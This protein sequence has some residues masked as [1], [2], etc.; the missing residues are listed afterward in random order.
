MMECA[1][2]GTTPT[3][4]VTVVDEHGTARTRCL[5]NA[6]AA[7]A[8]YPVPSAAQLLPTLRSLIAFI[9]TN[10]RMPSAAELQEIGGSG[11][12]SAAQPGSKDFQ[13]QLAYLEAVV[14]FTESQGRIR[15]EQEL[16]DRF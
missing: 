7:Q 5:C 15:T 9:K 8:G 14:E 16:R 11:D 10:Q 13:K 2:C 1:V 6:H 3:V 12:L 4:H